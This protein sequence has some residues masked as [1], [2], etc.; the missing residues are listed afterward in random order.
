M[1]PS[2]VTL[3]D[4]A[5]RIIRK[6]AIDAGTTFQAIALEAFVLWLRAN[7]HPS[8]KDLRDLKE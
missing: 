2:T 1:K 8:L 7:G 4:A 6:K 3:P 5:R